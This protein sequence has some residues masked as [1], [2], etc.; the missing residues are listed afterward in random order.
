MPSQFWNGCAMALTVV[1]LAVGLAED[2][3]KSQKNAKGKETVKE[4][5]Q[6]PE[7]GVAVLL[8][9]KGNDVRGIVMLSSEEKGVRV[10]G[11]VMGL[12]PGEHGFHIHEYGD[13]RAPDGASAGGHFNPRGHKHGGPDADEHH[14]G[15][16]GNI[17]ANDQGVA[18]VDK[19]AEDLELHFVVGRTVVVHAGADDFESQPSGDAGARVALGVIG[20]A[21]NENPKENQAAK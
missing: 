14:A 6:I 13:M 4:N 3:A 12:S 2:D 10:R 18:E 5:V 16:L 20:Y 7:V 11:R 15:D 8:P 9:T 21:N 17:T 1:G 19:F